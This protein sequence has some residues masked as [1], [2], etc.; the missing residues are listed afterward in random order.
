MAVIEVMQGMTKETIR[1]GALF[2]RLHYSA[3][4][5]KDSAWA[6]TGMNEESDPRNWEVQMEMR[7]VVIDGFPVYPRYVDKFH[8]PDSTHDVH[9]ELVPGSFYFAGWDVGTTLVPAFVLNELTPTLQIRSLLEVISIGGE[10]MGK[11][12]PRVRQELESVYPSIINQIRHFADPTVTTES[13]AD[14]KTAKEVAMREGFDLTP[15]TNVWAV[16]HTA[17]SEVVAL[18]LP[19]HPRYMVSGRGCPTL[20]RGFQGFYKF[21]ASKRGETDGP[22]AIVMVPLKNGYSHIH[23]ANQYSLIPIYDVIKPK[24]GGGMVTG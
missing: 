15:S 4:E 21:E 18:G 16:R 10:S 2:V 13:G 20:R 17:V 9:L 1:N 11:F 12:A 6:I 8:C 19:E 14:G 22:G 3:D 7:D 23:D 24:R 5:E